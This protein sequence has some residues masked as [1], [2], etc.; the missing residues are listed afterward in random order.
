MQT[1][2]LCVFIHI[3][4]KGEVGT[5]IFFL[6]IILLWILFVIFFVMLSCLFLAGWEKADL[7]ALLCVMFPCVFVTF[8]YDAQRRKRALMGRFSHFQFLTFFNRYMFKL[9]ICVLFVRKLYM[10]VLKYGFV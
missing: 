3:R 8:P 4:I 5:I 2:H 1:K 7:L 9:L 10:S 6:L